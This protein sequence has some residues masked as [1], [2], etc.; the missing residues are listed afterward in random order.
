MPA[1]LL[2]LLP[3]HVHQ[4]APDALTLSLVAAEG[5]VDLHRAWLDAATGPLRTGRAHVPAAGPL[6]SSDGVTIETPYLE[7]RLYDL[8]DVAPYDV[9]V[10]TVEPSDSPPATDHGSTAAA[11]RLHMDPR[12]VIVETTE[13]AA[14][15]LGMAPGALIGREGR[16]LIHPDDVDQSLA[17][18]QAVLAAPDQP[19]P[20][21]VRLHHADGTWRW[22]EAVNWN[23]LSDPGIRAV[24]TELRNV[25]Q[26]V[27]VEQ[28]GVASSRAHER[29]VR[30]LDE[31]DDIV[32]VGRLEV[33]LVYWNQA[34]EAKLPGIRPGV[35][36]TELMAPGLRQL[37]EA[38]V[39]PSLRRLERWSG[40]LDI[41]LRDGRVHTMATTVTPVL[42][43]AR[44]DLFYGVILRDVTADR[45]YAAELA[46]QARRD[47][48]TSLPNRLALSELLRDIEGDDVS[49]CFI[50]LDNLKVVNDGLGHGAGDKL[51]VSVT[52]ALLAV[53]GPG[54]VTRFGGD[55]FVVV[56]TGIGGIDAAATVAERLLAAIQAVRVPD[57]PTR[58]SASIG[59]AWTGIDD[60][61][62]EELIKD[63][64]TAMY[65]AKRR[66]KGRVAR[67]DHDQREAVTRRFVMETAL[68]QAIADDEI[69]V[70]LQPV[71][72][73]TDGTIAGFEALARWGLVA[74]TEFVATAEESGLIVPLGAR[75]LDRALAHL[76]RLDDHLRSLTRP[77]ATPST[78]LIRVAVNVS[79]RELVE[80]TFADR[81]LAAL[82]DHGLDPARLVLELTESV[83]IDTSDVVDR[84]LR[85]LRDAGVSLVLDDF[86]TGYSSIAYLRRYPIDGLKLDN[87]Y[88]RALLSH[89]D[90][91]VIA[92]TIIGLAHRLGLSIVAE[93][94]EEQSQLDVLRELGITWVQGYLLSPALPID[95]ILLGALGD[96]GARLR[97][98][99][100]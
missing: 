46:A 100:G 50:D 88:T 29:L 76:R 2:T 92:E 17:D 55:E 81:T 43:G 95:E 44:D 54:T 70:H 23:A 56:H 21:R 25:D 57:V 3:D 83:L 15:T 7:I 34:A 4:L 24:V 80:P 61:D 78:P 85:I 84:S 8:L 32:L 40:D 96:L 38:T 86:G 28:L 36:L 51:L 82:T 42:D 47:P 41:R 72:S 5:H 73:V 60:L 98:E 6:R 33:G 79:G 93:G 89:T 77:G 94:V 58:L 97:Q 68:Q 10:V 14:A 22:F 74:P 13:N 66:G 87:S 39:K 11:F 1:A 31:V 63:A 20:S 45:R 65:D 64:D 16:S 19:R 48:L 9:V 71:L 53:A 26:Q 59:V 49:L 62:A 75:V 90:T 67:F 12:G 52:E 37:T 18:W 69:D 27:R 35:P 99:P 91:R 30:V